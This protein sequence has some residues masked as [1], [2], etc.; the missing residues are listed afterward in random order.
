MRVERDA[1]GVVTLW[2][3]RPAVNNA[4]DGAMLAALH[5]AM[6]ALE[7]T[8]GARAV[9]LRGSGRHFQA[10]AD[11]DW[12]AA[13]RQQDAAGNLAASRLTAEAVDRLGRLPV[14]VLAL[15]HG[16]CFGGGTG[17]VAACDVVIAAEDAVFSVAEAR[18]GL[19]A[20]IIV[21]QLVDAIGARQT[22][23]FAL[24]GERFGAEEARRIGLVHEV[25]PRA[26][27]EET[28]ERLV[29]EILRN[30]PGA[31]AATKG[32]ILEHCW[33]G[34]QARGER[35]LEHL[36]RSHA[37]ARQGPEAAEG[38]AAFREGRSPAWAL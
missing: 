27:L 32:H 6:D 20:G 34:L 1:R 4:Y 26:G 30:G 7:G 38:L 29:R 17:I 33:A 16:A 19:H 13:V 31:V 15:V 18:W 11:L 12:L 8:D 35:D 24:T 3:N 2:L 14:P 5:A 25:V 22:R 37:Q 10:G 28:G 23:R 9:V 21:P 36:V